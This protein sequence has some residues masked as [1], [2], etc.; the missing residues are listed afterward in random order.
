MK[1]KTCRYQHFTYISVPK[2]MI[3][4]YS[5]PEIWHVT[6]F[7]FSFILGYFLPFYAQEIK[8][9]KWNNTLGNII[10]LRLC[11]KNYDHTIYGSWDM[12][13]HWRTDRQKIWYIYIERERWVPHMK[14]L[15]F[16]PNY[17]QPRKNPV[18]SVHFGSYRILIQILSQIYLTV[19][20]SWSFFHVL[21]FTP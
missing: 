3:I 12:G 19:S 6:N 8:I 17:S 18:K 21:G 16:F 2:I 5:I 10:I 4:C 9:K 1:I 7:Y 11:T 13:R 20:I 15:L 14:A